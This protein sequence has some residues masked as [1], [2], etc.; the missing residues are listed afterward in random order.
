MTLT[1][2]L[3][4][5]TQGYHFYDKLADIWK[6][7]CIFLRQKILPAIMP[8]INSSK[9]PSGVLSGGLMWR[10]S[11][12][13]SI[14][15]WW[16]IFR[17]VNVPAIIIAIIYGEWLRSTKIC[18]LVNWNTIMDVFSSKPRGRW[19]TFDSCSCGKLVLYVLQA[20]CSKDFCQ[21]Y[22]DIEQV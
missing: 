7:R 16:I 12:N 11:Q 13:S 20:A 8:F 3:T 22:L 5:I 10:I 15:S 9:S 6:F 21:L 19:G 1:D 4:H 14:F 17:V 2:R 18:V